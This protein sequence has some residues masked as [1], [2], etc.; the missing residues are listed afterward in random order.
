MNARTTAAALL[1]LA[2]FAPE[3]GQTAWAQAP[4]RPAATPSE[5][6]HIF[7]GVDVFGAGSYFLKEDVDENA[8][9]TDHYP[10]GWEAGATVF[11]GLRWVGL[12]G[13][14]GR[15]AYGSTPI[16]HVAVGPRVTTGW[17]VGDMLPVRFF[18]HGLAGYAMGS[19]PTGT[20]GGT[21]WV[22]GGGVDLA[23][24]RIQVDYVRLKIEGVPANNTRAFVGGVIS[25]CHRACAETDG[26][27]L[28]GIPA[29]K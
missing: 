12:T 24:L 20:Q 18:A 9:E 10:W 2:L 5:K 29:S 19:G 14:V 15:Q 23:F 17:I 8:E 22:A 11:V 16:T 13:S 26:L 3:G 21:E 7:L 4:P 25:L 28:S 1:A 6:P 27:N